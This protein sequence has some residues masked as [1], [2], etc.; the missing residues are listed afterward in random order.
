MQGCS[1]CDLE[2]LGLEAGTDTGDVLT[3]G[4]AEGR[5][6]LELVGLRELP[7]A[8]SLCAFVATEA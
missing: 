4:D 3:G 6:G 7:A 8:E 5:S 1:G 2:K